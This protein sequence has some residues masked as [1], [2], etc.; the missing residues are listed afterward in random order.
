MWSQDKSDDVDVVQ[1]TL[2]YYSFFDINTDY[3]VF[4][5]LEQLAVSTNGSISFWQNAFLNIELSL[6]NNWQNNKHTVTPGDFSFTYTQNFYSSKFKE[7]GFQ[8]LAPS[9]KLI[10]P[11]GR[12]EFGSG[13][14]NWILEPA[15]LYGWLLKD[16][17]FFIT[18]RMRA[19]FSIGRINNASV[20]DA[21]VRFEPRAGFE[22]ERFWASLIPDYRLIFKDTRST[23]LL[24]YEG[25][26]KINDK[27]GIG[28]FFSH[29]VIG[30]DFTMSN[31]NFS[32]YRIL[33]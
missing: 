33:N 4:E 31:L 23:L 8:G 5:D 12:A 3:Y 28:L 10:A 19:N 21:Y 17:R 25:G 29:R 22:N 32:Y 16:I 26:L 7:S 30:S 1:S 20:S 15:I 2:F 18:S 24:K 14:D 11:T 13:F 27:S 9:L 6:F